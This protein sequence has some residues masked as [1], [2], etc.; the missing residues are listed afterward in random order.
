MIRISNKLSIAF[1]WLYMQK[2]EKMEPIIEAI[3]LMEEHEEAQET[4]LKL[5]V[6]FAGIAVS[7][8]GNYCSDIC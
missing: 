1:E 4:A 5:D 3:D 8:G 7:N 2:G 6:D